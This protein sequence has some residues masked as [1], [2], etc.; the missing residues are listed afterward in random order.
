MTRPATPATEASTH[1]GRGLTATDQFLHRAFSALGPD[2]AAQY[3][4]ERAA[5]EFEAAVD[6]EVQ[7]FETQR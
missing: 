5:A 1:Q 2:V 6:A 3:A 4:F 7:R